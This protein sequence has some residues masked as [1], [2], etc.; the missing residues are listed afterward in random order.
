MR[1]KPAIEETQ[2]SVQIREIS[3]RQ[4]RPEAKSK[5][6]FLDRGHSESIEEI[7]K[8]SYNSYL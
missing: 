4:N 7:Y 6:C 8:H 5:D 3:Q 1:D 2:D